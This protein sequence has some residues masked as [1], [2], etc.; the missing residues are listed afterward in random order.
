MGTRKSGRT[1]VVRGTS[2][3]TPVTFKVYGVL[4]F[5][6]HYFSHRV[7]VA[8]IFLGHSW[9]STMELGSFKAVLGLPATNG[10]I[11]HLKQR[12]IG[13]IAAGFVQALFAVPEQFVAAGAVETH[14]LFYFRDNPVL[15]AAQW[16]AK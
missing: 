2:A 10:I 5:H 11:K 12:R 9:L 8:K 4:A 13:K 14:K 1:W 6:L 7:F 16:A 15:A 3:N